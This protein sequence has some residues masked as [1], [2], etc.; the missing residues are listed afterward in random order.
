MM[1]LR[2]ICKKL[3]FNNTS[4]PESIQEN[5]I[6]KILWDVEILTDNLIP[7]RRPV[8]GEKKENQNTPKTKRT[9]IRVDSA[10]SVDHWV[11]I[12]GNEERDKYLDLKIKENEE[13]VSGLLHRTKKADEHMGHVGTSCNWRAWIGL[14]WIRKAMKKL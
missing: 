2:E 4:K 11:K 7:A 5:E 8:T 13:R 1:I 10:L 14:H 6:H 12:K 3:K 9:F